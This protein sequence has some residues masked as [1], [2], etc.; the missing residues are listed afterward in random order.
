M[1]VRVSS[2]VPRDYKDCA[3]QRPNKTPS[4]H[5]AIQKIPDLGTA[6]EKSSGPTEGREGIEAYTEGLARLWV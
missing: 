1:N 3:G 4:G 2:S 6:A 5:P